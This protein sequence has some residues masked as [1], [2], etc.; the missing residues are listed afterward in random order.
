MGHT[1]R[2]KQLFVMCVHVFRY[3]SILCMNLCIF[4]YN[5]PSK[6]SQYIYICT[7]KDLGSNPPP[8]LR[9]GARN[10]GI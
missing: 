1:L 10:R 2:F 6:A 8:R 7:G 4:Y 3:D 9:Q 5:A